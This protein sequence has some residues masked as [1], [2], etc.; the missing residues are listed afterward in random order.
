MAF[1]LQ[2]TKRGQTTG[3]MLLLSPFGAGLTAS[4]AELSLTDSHDLFNV[5]ADLRESAHLHGRQRRAIG[6]QVCGAVSDDHHLQAPSQPNSLRPVGM[7]PRGPKGL[8][9]EPPVL[10]E[11][12]DK[13]PSV[14]ANALQQ[15]LGWI[16]GVEEDG[17]RAP[18][19]A[20]AG[21][22]EQLTRQR[23]LRRPALVP[24]ANAQE[25]HRRQDGGEPPGQ[26]R[27]ARPWG[28]KEEQIWV[29]TPASASALPYPP[30]VTRLIGSNR[31]S[32][33][34]KHQRARS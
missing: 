6:G 18:A 15:R 12:T 5:R 32:T 14:V 11:P 13:V 21:L 3:E 10:L 20:V 4:R 17:L 1:P 22:A 31:S 34:A 16:P 27:L 9:M 19:R 28:T 24:Y 29:R 7:A 2:D 25:G 26:H 8:V 33:R 23:L 30:R